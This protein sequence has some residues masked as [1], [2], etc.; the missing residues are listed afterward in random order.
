MNPLASHWFRV[1]LALFVLS[2]AVAFLIAL[3][4]AADFRFALVITLYVW[5]LVCGI[6]A[7]VAFA[8]LI[9]RLIGRGV[10][11]LRR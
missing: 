2:P 7:V 3:T 5:F 8:A 11:A 9:V 4:T 6:L 1:S 10:R